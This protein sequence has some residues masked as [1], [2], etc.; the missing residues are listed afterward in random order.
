M[1]DRGLSTTTRAGPRGIQGGFAATPHAMVR[2]ARVPHGF[3]AGA[4]LWL[5]L[6]CSSG[7]HFAAYFLLF[8]G[9][10]ISFCFFIAIF[11]SFCWCFVCLRLFFLRRGSM[12]TTHVSTTSGCD[13]GGLCNALRL[14][15]F[16]IHE[17]ACPCVPTPAGCFFSRCGA[18]SNA[19]AR[20]PRLAMGAADA[21][22]GEVV[23]ICRVIDVQLRVSRGVSL[24]CAWRF[25]FSREKAGQERGFL[26]F[27]K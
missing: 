9:R 26:Y 25:F 17:K 14:F 19:A 7:Y 3:V 20:L 8:W 27:A 12:D 11:F 6:A 23:S 18:S 21:V 16:K 10:D 4:L 13:R 24:C 15:P 22:Y 1:T 5:A 2:Y